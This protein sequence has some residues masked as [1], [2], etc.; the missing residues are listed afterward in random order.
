MKA[1]GW[2]TLI[3]GLLVLVGGV[4]G[5]IKASSTA[6]LVMGTVFGVLLMIAGA[7]T[8]K[9]RL[10]SAFS[11]ILL[12]FVLFAFFS[13]RYLITYNFFPSGLMSLLSIGTL[14]AIGL[15]MTTHLKRHQRK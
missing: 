15:L 11:A 13:Y 4:M 12:T 14:I 10:F 1:A 7:G 6:S 3:Y 5:H 8:L 9:D 2:I